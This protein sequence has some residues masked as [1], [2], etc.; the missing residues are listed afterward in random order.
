MGLFETLE[1]LIN[2]HGSAAILREHLALLH[3]EYAALERKNHDLGLEC[4][5][6]QTELEQLEI[7]CRELEQHLLHFHDQNPLAYRC[8]YCGS[9]RL[10]RS[11]SRPDPVFG[12]LGA[13]LAI[14]MCNDCGKE[15]A[16]SQNP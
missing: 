2:E 16:F 11:G 14:F 10:K 8:D 12:D 5:Q 4:Q 15:S 3:A 13:K 9:I 7:K 1:K 6:Q